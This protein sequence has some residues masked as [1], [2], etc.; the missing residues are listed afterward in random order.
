VRNSWPWIIATRA[1]DYR[2]TLDFAFVVLQYVSKTRC[3]HCMPYLP[4]HFVVFLKADYKLN[5]DFTHFPDVQLISM[6]LKW[7]NMCC[8]WHIFV[9]DCFNKYYYMAFQNSLFWLVDKPSVKNH[10]RTVV[11]IYFSSSGPVSRMSFIWREIFAL[12]TENFLLF[13][14]C[15]TWHAT[16]I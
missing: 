7:R 11:R 6:N 15:H 13:V 3:K 2:W 8:F 12:Q 9:S 14:A 1:R 5:W 16:F 10:I 4:A